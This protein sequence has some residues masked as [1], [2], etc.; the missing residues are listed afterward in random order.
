MRL[1][2]QQ[3]LQKPSRGAH[4]STLIVPTIYYFC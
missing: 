3:A 1:N 4:I 2:I